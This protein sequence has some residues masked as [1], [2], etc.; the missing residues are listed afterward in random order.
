MS[1]VQ[2]YVGTI[3]SCIDEEF[4]IVRSKFYQ[5]LTEQVQ[6]HKSFLNTKTSK[7][8]EFIKSQVCREASRIFETEVKG[9]L[10]SIIRSFELL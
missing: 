1:L 8:Q 2:D 10:N 7:E 9:S 4:R 6:M 5:N 3:V